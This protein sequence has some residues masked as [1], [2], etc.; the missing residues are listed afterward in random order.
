MCSFPEFKARHMVNGYDTGDGVQ[1]SRAPKVV[2][3]T[4]R[5]GFLE[6]FKNMRGWKFEDTNRIGKTWSYSAF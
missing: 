2:P 1:Y 3:K 5:L 4:T 6:F